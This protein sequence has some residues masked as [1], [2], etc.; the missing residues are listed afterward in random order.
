[1]E[2]TSVA[3]I[4]EMFCHLWETVIFSC[5][6]LVVV[7]CSTLIFKILQRCSVGFRRHT[8]PGHSLHFFF[9]FT[10]CC[11]IL[12]VCVGSLSCWNLPLLPSFWSLGVILSASFMVPS[13][14][15][16][17]PTPF[18]LMQPYHTPTSV[19]HCQ[20][21]AFTAVVLA[22]FTPDMLDP[23][24]SRN[25]FILVLSDQRMCFQYLSG[26]FS[27]SLAKFNLVSLGRRASKVFFLG[28]RQ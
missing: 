16:I 28:R 11:V 24:L 8:W 15:V 6:F 2:D 18:A 21:Y 25:K 23:H 22:R 10:N 19:L 20:D 5:S 14:N 13:V 4:S 17:S 1:M 7:C 12:A 27:C 26:F 3:H 9:F